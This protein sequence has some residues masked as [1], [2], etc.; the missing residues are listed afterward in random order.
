[1]TG[2]NVVHF[3]IPSLRERKEDILPLALKFLDKFNHEYGKSVAF[4]SQLMNFIEKYV[5]L[6]NVREL[7]NL[8]ERM[9][10]TAQKKV[11][12]LNNLPH[13]YME[14]SV[15]EEKSNSVGNLFQR[16]EAAEKNMIL[17]S[18]KINKTSIAVAKNLGI[19]QA[20][21]ARKLRKYVKVNIE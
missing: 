16:L 12:D 7:E 15:N 20:S 2:L 13:D 4:S 10:I 8:V 11:L 18:Y 21:A 6:G 17:E 1:E 19:S 9:V 3:H 5:W 14:D